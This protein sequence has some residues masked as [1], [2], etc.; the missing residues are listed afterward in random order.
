MMTEQERRAA[1]CG[2][3]TNNRGISICYR[4]GKAWGEEES[5]PPCPSEA[6]PEPISN[7]FIP[8]ATIFL[9]LVLSALVW[10]GM[11]L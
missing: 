8:Y 10:A 2:V 5:L 3:L 6:P 7:R 1:V 11:Q 9:A 4:C